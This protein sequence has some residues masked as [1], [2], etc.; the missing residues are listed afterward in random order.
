LLAEHLTQMP[1]LGLSQDEAREVVEYLR[2]Q[3]AK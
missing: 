1:N 2:E 3:K